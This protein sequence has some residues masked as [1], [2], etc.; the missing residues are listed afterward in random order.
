MKKSRTLQYEILDVLRNWYERTGA[1]IEFTT[2]DIVLQL[3]KD[4]TAVWE[5]LVH[6]SA[7]DAPLIVKVYEEDEDGRRIPARRSSGRG[8]P[9]DVYRYPPRKT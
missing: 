3:K 2:Q 9:G 8:R 6:M 1:V 5:A 7:G 4:R